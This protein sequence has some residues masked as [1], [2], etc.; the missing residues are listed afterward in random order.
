MD[1]TTND[2]HDGYFKQMASDPAIA[3]DIIRALLDPAVAAAIDW[4]TL[5]PLPTET[6]GKRGRTTRADL[7]YRVRLRGREA[8]II[9]VLEHQSTPDAMMLWRLLLYMVEQ[10][11]RWL[12]D[13]RGARHLPPI[14]PIVIYN[15]RRPWRAPLDFQSLFRRCPPEVLDPLRPY[16]PDFR[17]LLDDLTR[18]DDARIEADHTLALAIVALLSL[19][20]GHGGDYGSITALLARHIP[21]AKRAPGGRDALDRTLDYV[22]R[23]VDDPVV[24]EKIAGEL[25]PETAEVFMG[26]AETFKRVGREEGLEKGREE[27]RE[28]GREQGRE[29]GREE[30]LLLALTHKFGAVPD[31]VTARIRAATAEQRN[32]WFSRIF[33]ARTLD[34]LFDA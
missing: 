3:A 28:E 27:G 21:A 30:M 4:S 6:K 14:V 25:E 15:G 26:L 31:A 33:V 13:N 20:H 8:F 29:Q 9:V 17:V 19:K 12:E 23:H 24:F 1:E 5:E 32:R 7:I 16:L 18:T 10:W 2:P 11:R 22:Y 34:E